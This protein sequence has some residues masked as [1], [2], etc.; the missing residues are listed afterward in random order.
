M[1]ELAQDLD[2]ADVERGIRR[3]FQPQ[4][5]RV[6][7]KLGAHHSMLGGVDER[8]PQVAGRGQIAQLFAGAVITLVRGDDAF[9]GAQQ[10]EYRKGGRGSRGECDGI[11][12]AFELRDAF[13]QSAAAR[14]IRASVGVT[15]RE[16]AVRAAFKGGAQVNCRSDIARAGFY[17]PPRMNRQR[18]NLHAGS[19]SLPRQDE[20]QSLVVQ[21]HAIARDA[22]QCRALVELLPFRVLVPV[23][24]DETALR[25]RCVHVQV[26]MQFRQSRRGA[27]GQVIDRRQGFLV[28]TAG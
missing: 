12:A 4:Q 18:F 9:A 24:R 10:A 27:P 1:G 22:L 21:H 7:L 23:D 15:A 20:T 19:P 17:R 11:D 28:R 16:V 26:Q 6:K 13:L 25:G 2:I 8:R 3:R 14:I 5:L